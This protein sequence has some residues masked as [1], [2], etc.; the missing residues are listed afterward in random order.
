MKRQLGVRERTFAP[1]KAIAT[2]STD[3]PARR[4]SERLAKAMWG[5]IC[6][7]AD[8]RGHDRAVT[9]VRMQNCDPTL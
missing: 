3:G 5:V 7:Y 2:L 1:V 8:R 9:A 4:G 6:R